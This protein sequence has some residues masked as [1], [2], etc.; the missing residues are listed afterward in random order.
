M[1]IAEEPRA[2]EARSACRP[3]HPGGARHPYRHLRA[4]QRTRLHP[5]ETLCAGG[6]TYL[7]FKRLISPPRWGGALRC[8][9]QTR[10][11]TTGHKSRRQ[12]VFMPDS[13]LLGSHAQVQSGCAYSVRL[14]RRSPRWNCKQNTEPSSRATTSTPSTNSALAYPWHDACQQTGLTPDRFV[15]TPPVR[16][17]HHAALWPWTTQCRVLCGPKLKECGQKRSL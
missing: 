16:L 9:A 14:M 8:T 17:I 15:A 3:R 5:R 13:E 10:H 11:P 1:G 6:P 4:R 7:T 2:P 12:K